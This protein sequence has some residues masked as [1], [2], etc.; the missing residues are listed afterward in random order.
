MIS[1]RGLLDGERVTL[2]GEH[3]QLTDAWCDP[4][5]IQP[6]IPI[7]VGGAGRRVHRIAARERWG[8]SH[9]TV[10]RDALGQLEPVIEAL[11]GRD[12]GGAKGPGR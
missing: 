5:P 4:R 2:H 11:T 12:E 6:R 1:L 9:Y 3:H 10:R 8:F 7:L